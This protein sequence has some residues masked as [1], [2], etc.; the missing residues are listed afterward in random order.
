MIVA[1]GVQETRPRT[2]R[3]DKPWQ[4]VTSLIMLQA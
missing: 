3:H 1:C 4:E 2:Q